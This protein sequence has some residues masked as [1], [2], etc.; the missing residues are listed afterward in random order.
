MA[1]SLEPAAASGMII[2]AIQALAVQALGGSGV[3]LSPKSSAKLLDKA[4]SGTAQS[5][6]LHIA[7]HR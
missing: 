3:Q 5:S 1:L 6:R 7:K 2:P 4:F